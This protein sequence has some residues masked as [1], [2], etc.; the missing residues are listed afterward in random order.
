MRALGPVTPFLLIAEE[1]AVDDEY[2][3]VHIATLGDADITATGAQSTSPEVPASLVERGEWSIVHAGRWHRAGDHITL[4]EA[5]TRLW[6][7]KHLSRA[8]RNY[9]RR[10]LLLL[11]DNMST[12]VAGSRGR[13][14]DFRLLCRLRAGLAYFLTCD[15]FVS[16]RWLKSERN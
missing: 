7:L 4:L 13:C 10:H 2:S 6:V 15:L 8:A 14:S 1:H 9:G 12:V 16:D 3:E 11:G 5:S